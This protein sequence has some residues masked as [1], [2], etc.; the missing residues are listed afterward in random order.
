MQHKKSGPE[1]HFVRS[2][3]RSRM[4]MAMVLVFCTVLWR[5]ITCS[6][7]AA[8]ATLTALAIC[9]LAARATAARTHAASCLLIG[10]SGGVATF[11]VK[12]KRSAAQTKQLQDYY[13]RNVAPETKAEREAVAQLK[14]QLASLKPPTV[15]IMQELPV[16]QRRKTFIQLRGNWQALGDEV[17]AGVPAAC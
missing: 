17:T 10:N 4:V 5:T 6:T 14:Q 8:V 15:P 1:A 3:K 9:A 2:T 12:E 13:V 11:I 7:F 16:A